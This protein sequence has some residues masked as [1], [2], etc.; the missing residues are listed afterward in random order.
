MSIKGQR[1]AIRRTEL[2][3][4]ED[5][6]PL[7]EVPVVSA[8]HDDGAV[9][10]LAEVVITGREL[11]DAKEEFERLD[12]RYKRARNDDGSFGLAVVE[13]VY[14]QHGAGIQALKRAIAEAAIAEDSLV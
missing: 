5:T 1:I 13:T 6:L 4:V 12:V 7:W 9:K 11:P 3:T 2:H 14:G 10:V 8:V